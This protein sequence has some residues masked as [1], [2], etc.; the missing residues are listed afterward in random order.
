MPKFVSN[1]IE[2]VINVRL[3]EDDLLEFKIHP[4]G[5]NGTMWIKESVIA[6]QTLRSKKFKSFFENQGDDICDI[7]DLR[8]LLKENINQNDDYDDDVEE[9]SED[10]NMNANETKADDCERIKIKINNKIKWCGIKSLRK[11]SYFDAMFSDRWMKNRDLKTAA[12]DLFGENNSNSNDNSN[13][14]D[15]NNFDFI[16]LEWLLKCVKVS[17]I[18]DDLPRDCELIEGLINCND[19]L[20]NKQDSI[21]NVESLVKYFKKSKPRMTPD[22]RRLLRRDAKHPVLKQALKNYKQEFVDKIQEMRTDLANNHSTIQSLSKIQFDNKTAIMLLKE[23]L[24]FTIKKIENRKILSI[25]IENFTNTQD[26]INLLQLIKKDSDKYSLSQIDSLMNVIDEINKPE[27][28][29]Y[30]LKVPLVRKV[31]VSC[32][33]NLID[34]YSGKIQRARREQSVNVNY[35]MDDHRLRLLSLFTARWKLVFFCRHSFAFF[36]NAEAIFESLLQNLVAG[37]RDS[38]SDAKGVEFVEKFA[39]FVFEINDAIMKRY[40]PNDSTNLSDES[41]LELETGLKNVYKMWKMC[42]L[43]CSDEWIVNNMELW[44]PIVH[45]NDKHS[46]EWIMKDLVNDMDSATAW[47]F[48]IYLTKYIAY[49]WDSK[50]KF[51]QKYLDFLKNDL[52]INWNLTYDQEKE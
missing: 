19:F 24:K 50:D 52:E 37:D 3:C 38:D 9:E 45:E 1:D 7:D 49:K 43:N 33:Q 31:L 42:L 36:L 28:H 25:S 26:Y 5:E 35:N 14:N 48:G 51:P 47:N 40:S 18:R 30:T 41:K 17:K 8:N 27:H 16:H 22:E 15:N 23:K 20:M 44:F 32:V 2:D 21:I 29:L 11:L 39:T 46:V 10:N 12:I 4:S 34:G 13:N 6:R